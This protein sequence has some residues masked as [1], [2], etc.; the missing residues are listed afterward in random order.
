MA[1]G[2]PKGGGRPMDIGFRDLMEE[3]DA[4]PFPEDFRLDVYDDDSIDDPSEIDRD[5]DYN[6][7]EFGEYD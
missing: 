6:P 1:R 2:R 7:D 4:R 5:I 3:V